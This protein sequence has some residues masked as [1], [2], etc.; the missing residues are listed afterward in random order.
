L[1]TFPRFAGED[2][3]PL[4]ALIAAYHESE[5]PGRPLRATLP[6]AGR[7]LLERQA[8]LAASAG[9]RR[10]IVAV[11]RIPP[12]LLSAIDRLRAGGLAVAIARDAPEAAEAVDPGE[13]L[14]LVADGCI[15][16]EA[17]VRRLA[18]ASGLAVLAIPDAGLDDRYER[19]DAEW[20]WAGLAVIDG[21]LLRETAPMLGDWDLQSTLLRRALQSGARRLPLRGEPADAQLLLVERRADLGGVQ[22][23]ILERVPTGR[24]DWVSRYLLAPLERAGTR[25][26]MGS[27]VTPRALGIAAAVL[28]FAGA[29]AFAWNL[30]WLGLLF[31]LLAT[32]LDGMIDR[33][34]RL[35]MQ[36]SGRDSWWSHLILAFAAAALLT[37]SFALG[38][39]G[40][41]WGCVALAAGIIAFLLALRFEIEG[42]Q[43]DGQIFLAERKGMTW[44][45]LPFAAAGFWVTGLAVLFAY[46]AGSFF[47]AQRCV[48]GAL[49]AQVQ[50]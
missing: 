25:L 45:F 3:L 30:L 16:D 21:A 26:L 39:R 40:N 48:H 19:I 2:G 6:L 29:V 13:R 15:A 20:R 44:L 38:E 33:L 7:T 8:R 5:E 50:D 11:E 35:R 9:A 18:E 42:R 32:P 46:A 36:D 31:L 49:E 22:Q 41:G 28:T 24:G 43:V 27:A 47:W 4:A 10:I 12:E 23:R 17:H 37:L 1:P 14:L 34:A